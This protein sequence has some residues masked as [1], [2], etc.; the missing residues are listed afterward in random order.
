M[1]I[2]GSS[3]LLW[4]AESVT[5]TPETTTET[6]ADE[7]LTTFDKQRALIDRAQRYDTSGTLHLWMDYDRT[8]AMCKRRKKA[9][10]A[11]KLA[12]QL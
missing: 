4:P 1:A 2:G 5:M 10:E 12:R 7:M 6:A 11:R 8:E 3:R 9:F